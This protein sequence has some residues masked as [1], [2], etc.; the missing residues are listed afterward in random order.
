MYEYYT[1]L[2]C[3]Q[4]FTSRTNVTSQ[5]NQNLP[6]DSAPKELITTELKQLVYDPIHN[7]LL[8]GEMYL[9]SLTL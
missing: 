1:P 9:F 3:H 4:L 6:K 8:I 7:L 2:K 5:M